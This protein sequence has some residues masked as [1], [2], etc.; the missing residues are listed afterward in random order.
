LPPV[1]SSSA[2]DQFN[3][4]MQGQQATSMQ[5]HHHHQQQCWASPPASCNPSGMHVTA[6]GEGALAQAEGEAYSLQLCTMLGRAQCLAAR[7]DHCRC[8]RTHHMSAGIP[9]NLTGLGS[10]N[11]PGPD[12]GSSSSGGGG[13]ETSGAGGAPGPAAPP[14]LCIK[15]TWQPNVRKRKKTHGFL[16]R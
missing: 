9:I 7:P 13:G 2:A 3:T 12:A 14:L 15:R 1:A 8:R 11:E 16:K 4:W 6:L 10:L 5:Q